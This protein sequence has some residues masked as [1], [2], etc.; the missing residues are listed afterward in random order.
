[1]FDKRVQCCPPEDFTLIFD[2]KKTIL[3]VKIP[4]LMVKRRLHIFT[5]FHGFKHDNDIYSAYS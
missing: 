1:M 2:G 4:F 3:M 5:K